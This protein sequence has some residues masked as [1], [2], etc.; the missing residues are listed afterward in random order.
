MNSRRNAS[1]SPARVVVLGGANTDFLVRAP[2]LPQPGET[3]TGVEFDHAAA[4]GKGANQAVAAAR[5]GARV[6]FLGRVGADE[7]GRVLLG[8]LDEEGVDVRHVAKDRRAAT[9]VALISVDAAGEKQITVAPGAN[10]RCSVWDVAG[11]AAVIAGAGVLVLQFE[12]PMKANLAAARIAQRTGVPILLDPAPAAVVPRELLRLVTI[13]RANE[14]EAEALT[15]VPVKDRRSARVAAGQLTKLGIR[16]AIIAAGKGNLVVWTSGEGFDAGELWL[17]RL[18][19]K[20]IDATGAGDAFAAALAVAVAEGQPIATA[21]VFANA[22]AALATT[23]LG[24]QEALPK[25]AA[26]LALLRRHGGKE[27]ARRFA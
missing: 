19:V 24:A 10:V 13:L 1:S 6:A 11:A 25:R 16:T 21:A 12:I 7:R 20:A 22:A 15:G 18:P 4:G 26:V 23:K 9:G 17:P 3:V 8:R 27:E 14:Y 5:L 2:R